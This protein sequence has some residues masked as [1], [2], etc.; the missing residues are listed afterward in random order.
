MRTY[1]ARKHFQSKNLRTLD[2]GWSLQGHECIEMMGVHWCSLN[3]NNPYN[4]NNAT[5][6]RTHV[7]LHQGVAQ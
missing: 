2:E 4:S 6:L 5:N 3:P 1:I 7:T